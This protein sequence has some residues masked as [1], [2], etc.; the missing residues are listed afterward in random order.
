MRTLSISP[1]RAHPRS[2]GENASEALYSSLAAG[3]SPLTRRKRQKVHARDPGAGLIPAHAGK[4]PRGSPT[5]R[6]PWAHPRSRGENILRALFTQITMGSSPLTR[7]KPWTAHRPHR[8]A[9]LIPA[10]AGKTTSSSASPT[11]RR[12][13]PR[14]RGENTYAGEDRNLALGSSPLTRGKQPLAKTGAFDKGLIPAHAGKT[15]QARYWRAPARAHPRSRGE[16]A[17]RT[18]DVLVAPGSSPLTRGKRGLLVGQLSHGGLI[19]AHAGKTAPGRRDGRG[20]G[21]HPRSRGENR[22]SWRICSMILG[23]SPLTRGKRNIDLRLR[24][25]DGL[26]PAHA[27]KTS[28]AWKFSMMGSGSSP[29]TRGKRLLGRRLRAVQRLIPA[30]AGKTRSRLCWTPSSRAHP[31]SRGE[32]KIQ[33]AL[34]T[35]SAGSSPLTRGKLEVFHS[36]IVSDRLI[37][38]HAGKTPR[39][40]PHCEMSRAHPRSRGENPPIAWS[41]P[42]PPGSSPLTRGKPPW[43]CVECARNGLIPAHAGKTSRMSAFF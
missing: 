4:T 28:R 32:N 14:S 29:L 5:S 41:D 15:V 12:A 39:N 25:V 3:S 33:E 18:V 30:H 37:P 42:T 35:N 7:G 23:S 40:S 31:R 6:T 13:H 11:T 10:H 24:G 1:S 27:G 19:P 36:L 17:G 21:A 34:K 38:A 20:P 43:C 9:G 26:I 8:P 2:R 22:R 16:N